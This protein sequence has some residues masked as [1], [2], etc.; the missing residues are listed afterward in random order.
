MTDLRVLKNHVL[1]F[2]QSYKERFPESRRLFNDIAKEYYAR[3]QSVLEAGDDVHPEEERGWGDRA[4][5]SYGWTADKAGKGWRGAKG[6][7]DWSTDKASKGWRGA[8]D[9]YNWTADKAGK[10]WRG[11]KAAYKWAK[12][13]SSWLA[14]KTTA[15]LAK[16]RTEADK[17]YQKAKKLKNRGKQ[18]VCRSAKRRCN[19]ITVEECE[20]SKAKLLEKLEKAVEKQSRENLKDRIEARAGSGEEDNSIAG[21]I[22]RRRE[23]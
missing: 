21:R 13:T 5:D 4:R 23:E 20:K 14:G 11:T 18:A 8:K 16:L 9:A 2:E 6:A 3:V 17:M 12:D 19:M 10:C 7:Y 22:R 15:L 1:T